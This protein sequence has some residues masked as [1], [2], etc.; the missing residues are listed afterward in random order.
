MPHISSAIWSPHLDSNLLSVLITLQSVLQDYAA[1]VCLPH[2]C[3]HTKIFGQ[4]TEGNAH[5]DGAIKSLYPL[6]SNG[7]YHTIFH[8]NVCCLMKTFSISS[9]QVHFIINNYYHLK[10]F[11]FP[12]WEN[13]NPQGLP[14]NALG[15]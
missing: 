5:A 1:P 7:W 12:T 9:Q 13:V 6:F 3:S 10:P 4:L 8:Q 11:C 15:R 2:I 14:Y